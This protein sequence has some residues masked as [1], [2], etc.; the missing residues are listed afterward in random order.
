M[1]IYLIEKKIAS[2]NGL[3]V[4]ILNEEIRQNESVH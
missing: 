4:N 2:L 3:I 1:Y